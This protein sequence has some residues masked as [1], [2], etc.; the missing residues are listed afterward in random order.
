MTKEKKFTARGFRI[1]DE[2]VDKYHSSVDVVQSSLATDD[3]VWVLVKSQDPSYSNEG[4]IHLTVENAKR[5][6]KALKEWI[7]DVETWQ[8]R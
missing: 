1:Y 4:A 5:L 2:F 8:D 6:R 7:K 3:C